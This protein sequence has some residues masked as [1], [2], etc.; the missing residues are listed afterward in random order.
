MA[1]SCRLA[2]AIHPVFQLAAREVLADT[3]R[4]STL[5]ALPFMGVMG[6]G[7]VMGW[8]MMGGCGWG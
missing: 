4:Q 6:W 7:G 5:A 8:R 1:S 3:N 2:A